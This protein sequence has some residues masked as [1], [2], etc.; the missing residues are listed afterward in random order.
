MMP[1]TDWLGLARESVFNP[2]LAARAILRMGLPMKV[3]RQALLL[4][5]ILTDLLMFAELA[6]GGGATFLLGTAVPDPI[7]LAG[8]QFASLVVTSLALYG[9]GRMFGGRGDLAGAMALVIWMQVIMLGFGLA[10]T[11]AY[12][13]LPGLGNALGLASIVMMLWLLTQ[14]TLELHGFTNAWLVFL[15]IIAGALVLVF[16]LSFLLMAFGVFVPGVA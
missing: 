3:L 9:I 5:S 15:G 14:F 16:G 10:Q 7:A 4:V 13:L 2:R 11:V 1:Q 12:F 8:M 6:A